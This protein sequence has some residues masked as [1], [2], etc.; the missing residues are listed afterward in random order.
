MFDLKKVIRVL[1]RTI[2]VSIFG[3]FLEKDHKSM[4]L[5]VNLYQSDNLNN[6]FEF[7]LKVLIDFSST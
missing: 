3:M 6:Y 5:S 7:K 4:P 2:Q 1:I